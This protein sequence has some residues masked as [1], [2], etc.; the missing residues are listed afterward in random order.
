MKTVSVRDLQKNVKE[1]VDESQEDRVVIT[2]HGR[3]AAVLVGVEGED[4]EDIVLQTDPS[5][6]KLIRKRRKE[7]TISLDELKA[8]LKK[9]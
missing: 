4:W 2:R 5:F 6:W 8:E 1:C 3:P 9:G 7:K